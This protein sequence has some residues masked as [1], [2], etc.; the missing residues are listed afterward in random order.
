[1]ISVCLFSDYDVSIVLL[2]RYHWGMS[3]VSLCWYCDSI[4]LLCDYRM[5]II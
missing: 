3:V 4:V 1:M 2:W 5:S